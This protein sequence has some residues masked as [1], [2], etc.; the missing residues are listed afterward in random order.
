MSASE[1]SVTWRNLNQC[2]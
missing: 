2:S 1:A